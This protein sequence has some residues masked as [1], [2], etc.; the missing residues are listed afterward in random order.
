MNK[1]DKLASLLPIGLFLS[2]VSLTKIIS[3]LQQVAVAMFRTDS[4][5]QAWLVQE[6]WT[7]TGS[8]HGCALTGFRLKCTSL[9]QNMKERCRPL[10]RN[11]WRP[12]QAEDVPRLCGW[13][14]PFI[15][16][17]PCCAPSL[18][19]LQLGQCTDR[20]QRLHEHTHSTAR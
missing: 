13:V 3:V 5:V 1:G 6:S 12:E 16:R 17:K 8:A 15:T 19:S 4:G 7:S 20:A 18:I 10:P 9:S 11:Y 2:T 14:V